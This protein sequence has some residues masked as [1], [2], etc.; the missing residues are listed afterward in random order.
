VN[1]QNPLEL[2]HVF[3]LTNQHLWRELKH[4]AEASVL[5]PL[6][7]KHVAALTNALAHRRS[8]TMRFSSLVSATAYAP[9]KPLLLT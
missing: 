6:E 2:K 3:P 1:T 4:V 8:V 7:L 9:Q 5:N